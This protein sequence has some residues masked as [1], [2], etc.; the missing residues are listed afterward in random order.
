[1][2]TRPSSYL[3]M[4]TI[5]IFAFSG[6]L[7][8][9]SDI[10]TPEQFFGFQ[11]GADGQLANWDK[12]IKYFETLDLRSDRLILQNLGPSTLDNP[13]LL[14]IISSADNLKNL[15]R[16]RLINKQLT[17]PRG[18]DADQINQLIQQGKFICAQT[19]S[20]HATEV[21]GTQ[22]VNELAYD[23]ITAEDDTTKMIRENTIFLLF[24]CFNPDGLNMVA[25][26]FYKYQNTEFNN[27]SLP[28]LYHFYTGHDDNRDSYMLTQKES[29]MFAKIVYRDWQPQVY[30][31]HHHMGG[32]SARF[33]IPPYLDP[34]HPNVDPLIWREHQLYGAHMAVALEQAD[35]SGFETGA[36][37]T[38]WWQASFHM[39]TNYHNIAGMLTESAGADWCDP[40]FVMPDQLGSTRGRPEYKPQMTMPRLWPGGW[41]RLR[42]IV[43]QQIIASKAVLELGARYKETMLRNSVR[44]AMGNVEKGQNEAPYA[45]ILPKDQHDFLSAVKLARI[46]QVNGVEIHRLDAPYQVGTQ[47]FAPGSFVISCAQPLRAFVVSFLEQVNYPDNN[48]T[49]EH[50]T[51]DPI[52]PYDLAAYSVSEQMGVDAIPM[53]EPLRDIAMTVIEGDITPP[54]GHVDEN[55]RNAFIFE[56]RFNDSFK[57]ANR[58]WKEGADIFV[59]EGD[60]TLN[61]KYF[62]PGAFMVQS[63]DDISDLAEEVGKDL[64]LDFYVQRDRRRLP[65]RRLERPRLGLY[66]RFAGGNMDEGWTNW[67]LQDFEFEFDSLFNADIRDKA[68]AEKYNVIILPS[69]SYSQMVNGDDSRTT[70]PEF[71]DGMGQLGLANIKE[72]VEKG[73]ILIALNQS[74]DLARQVF[75]LP[76]TDTIAGV[77]SRDF[78]CPGSTVKLSVDTTHPLG[79]GFQPKVFGLY[80]GSPV[81][82]VRTGDFADK[83]GV[84]AKYHEENILQSGWLIGEKYLSGKSVIMD[85]QV[86]AGKV[87]LLAL[88][89][90]H[91]AQTHGTYKFLFNAICY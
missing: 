36:P 71:R 88:P 3:L 80:R 6:T 51:Q 11:M 8:A 55:G 61:G 12:I 31:D 13:F 67:M 50:T 64:G 2:K 1:M 79:Y 83:I 40:V 87:V 27:T 28:Y 85:F 41:W 34:I 72:F 42:D 20:L 81:L 25:E 78:Y 89:V 14:A 33:Y 74:A 10:P 24:P 43:E 9:Q 86:G 19:Y 26:W 21:G 65:S 47:V 15:E 63:R 17:D 52:R 22:C 90:Q 46:F 84:A 77:A 23:L 53:L 18:L 45:Y 16:Y 54:A 30:V 70:P 44:K 73:G 91:R 39:S 7:I 5:L 69:D 56:R 66:K 35:K 59:M 4:S 75:N 62:A 57:A 49:R 68:L 60:F 48:W 58:F 38:G 37:Y 82:T 76:I 29:R 32:S